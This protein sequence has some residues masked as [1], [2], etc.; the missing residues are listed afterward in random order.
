MKK[1][2]KVRIFKSPTCSVL[3]KK[4]NEFLSSDDATEITSIQYATAS[5]SASTV[6]PSTVYTAM[7]VYEPNI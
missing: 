2:I 7:V 4:V 6:E 1:S 5:N 3:E